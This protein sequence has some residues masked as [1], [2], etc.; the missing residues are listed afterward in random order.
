MECERG[1]CSVFTIDPNRVQNY[2]TSPPRMVMKPTG[3]TFPW[4]DLDQPDKGPLPSGE[5]HQPEF[6][7]MSL[8][9]RSLR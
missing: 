9:R 5:T 1:S 3:L 2:S 6:L 8:R 7:P 4:L